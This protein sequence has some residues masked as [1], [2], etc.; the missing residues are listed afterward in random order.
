[1]A[2]YEVMTGNFLFAYVESVGHALPSVYVPNQPNFLTQ[3]DVDAL[4]NHF[5][6]SI[7][8]HAVLSNFRNSVGAGSAYQFLVDTDMDPFVKVRTSLSWR[9]VVKMLFRELAADGSLT[10]TP[11]DA[12]DGHGQLTYFA[13]TD[14]PP[15]AGGDGVVADDT[16]ELSSTEDGD[17]DEF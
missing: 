5:L 13:V 10:W 15:L 11:V 16:Y 6:H 9:T 14:V 17:D 1:M 3:A 7:P 8:R 12:N 4:Q 2:N